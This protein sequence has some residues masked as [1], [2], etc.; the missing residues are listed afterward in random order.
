MDDVPALGKEEIVDLQTELARQRLHGGDMCL[1]A[2]LT[3]RNGSRGVLYRHTWSGRGG[4]RV[5]H[6]ADLGCMIVLRREDCRSEP[7]KI[8]AVWRKESLSSM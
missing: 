4:Q 5:R 8:R 1:R 6:L 3:V 7:A 2:R